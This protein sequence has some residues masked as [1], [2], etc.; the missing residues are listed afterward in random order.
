MERPASC[1]SSRQRCWMAQAAS[2][3]WA[4]SSKRAMISSPMVLTTVPSWTIVKAT[5][6]LIASSMIDLAF[7]LPTCLYNAELPD[8]SANMMACCWVGGRSEEH[9]SELQSRENLVCRLLLEK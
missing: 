9:T 5:M 6:K 4:Q 8:T 3:A 2:Q 7:S 1:G